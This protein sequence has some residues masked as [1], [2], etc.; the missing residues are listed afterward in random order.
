MVFLGSGIA[1]FMGFM[2][3]EMHKWDPVG[4]IEHLVHAIAVE[5]FMTF[6]LFSLL[7]MIWGL[8]T[9]LWLERLLR[10]GFRKLT[11]I[12][13]VIGVGTFLSVGF[14]LLTR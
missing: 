3:S 11:M 2:L 10:G 7:A 13:T 12:F 9:P 6:G 4:I 14:Y 5:I 1:A 8:F